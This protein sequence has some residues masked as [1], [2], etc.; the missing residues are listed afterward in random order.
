MKCH[1]HPLTFQLVVFHRLGRCLNS[2]A[3]DTVTKQEKGQMADAI[4]LHAE[5]DSDSWPPVAL[6]GIEA[7]PCTVA[8]AFDC[9]YDAKSL[10][11]L[12]YLTGLR[13][14]MCSGIS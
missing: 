8:A 1:C 3:A 7:A 4:T 2:L 12:H 10:Y 5:D 11:G 9:Y 13:L 6:M 14:P